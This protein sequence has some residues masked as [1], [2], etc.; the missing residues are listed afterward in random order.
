MNWMKNRNPVWANTIEIF[1]E[2]ALELRIQVLAFMKKNLAKWWAQDVIGLEYV[3]T[4]ETTIR[5]E[6]RFGVLSGL[7]NVT[8]QPSDIEHWFVL[9]SDRFAYTSTSC[10]FATAFCFQF[11]IKVW[12]KGSK[13]PEVYSS[14]TWGN[15]DE[16]FDPDT[17]VCLMKADRT[18]HFDACQFIPPVVYVQNLE[19]KKGKGRL[20]QSR[21]KSS[22]EISSKKRNK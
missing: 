8:T 20:R 17:T 3:D 15:F 4:F 6:M 9:M 19:Q 16:Q 18:G 10:I 5:D 1:P 2:S 13:K 12:F 11:R 22:I 7:T 21:L 14:L